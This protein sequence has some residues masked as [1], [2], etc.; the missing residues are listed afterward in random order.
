MWTGPRFARRSP[1]RRIIPAVGGGLQRRLGAARPA[2]LAQAARPAQPIGVQFLRTGAFCAIFAPPE[3]LGAAGPAVPTPPAGG[4][5]G[6]CDRHERRDRR[7]GSGGREGKRAIWVP[8]LPLL[9]EILGWAD[10]AIAAIRPR[11]DTPGRGAA[12]S[13]RVV[14]PTSPARPAGKIGTTGRLGTGG[15]GRLGQRP[16]TPVPSPVTIRGGPGPPPPHHRQHPPD[17]PYGSR[18][19]HRSCGPGRPPGG[20]PGRRGRP[21]RWYSRG[22]ARLAPESPDRIHSIEYQ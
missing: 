1:A 13:A 19:S 10:P 7:G 2:R 14:G 18:R 11:P 15:G 6:P 20:L 4:R 5:P 8:F 22:V 12:Q 3:T 9:P 17:R 21:H 16:G